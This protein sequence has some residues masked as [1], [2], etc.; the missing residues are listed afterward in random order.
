MPGAVSG[1]ESDHRTVPGYRLGQLLHCFLY[2]GSAA[3]SGPVTPVAPVGDATRPP[4]VDLI[5]RRLTMVPTNRGVTALTGSMVA[6]LDAY[7]RLSLQ[8]HDG[9]R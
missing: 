7:Y 3:F 2:P 8:L 9:V 4:G 1:S 5:P 6:G